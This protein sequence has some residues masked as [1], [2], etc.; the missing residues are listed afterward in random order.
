M[1]GDRWCCGAYL[2]GDEADGRRSK[3]AV[4]VSTQVSNSS[5]RHLLKFGPCCL[6]EA[7]R[8]YS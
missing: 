1:S 2:Y 3:F 8:G 6:R 7:G 5:E 4:I